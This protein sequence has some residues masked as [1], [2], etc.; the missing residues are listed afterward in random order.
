[1]M[2]CKYL[3]WWLR[4]GKSVSVDWRDRENI[5]IKLSFVLILNIKVHP[6]RVT[7]GHN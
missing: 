4:W 7:L 5:K 6:L 1:M 2:N 3:L